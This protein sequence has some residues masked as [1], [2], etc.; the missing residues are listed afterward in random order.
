MTNLD[1]A[2]WMDRN[3]RPASARPGKLEERDV[4]VRGS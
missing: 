4:H 1:P 3:L 2:G